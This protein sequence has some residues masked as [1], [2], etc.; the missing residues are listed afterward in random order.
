MIS[1]K[2]RNPHCEAGSRAGKPVAA[3][4]ADSS[5]LTFDPGL[6]EEFGAEELAE[7]MA[8]RSRIHAR[9]GISPD[10]QP[11]ALRTGP[12]GPRTPGGK[13]TSSANSLKHGLASGRLII[14]GEDAADF[15]ALL[16]DL[17]GD[18]APATETE[19]L[20]VQQMAQSW[21]LLQRA[22]RFQNQAFTETRC[23]VLKL[24]LFLR[25]QTT[26]ERAFYKALNTLLKLQKERRKTHPE[27]VSQKRSAPPVPP[28]F[29]SKKSTRGIRSL[30][31]EPS[32]PSR[33]LKRN[34]R[35]RIGASPAQAAETEPEA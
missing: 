11:P 16:S 31:S 34:D 25:Y 32:A 5:S 14:P 4:G 35:G 29:V 10:P 28:E 13:A 26:Y 17:T 8:L 24:T 18:H 15:E 1:R 3:S 23:D 22:I 12:T 27:F 21:W 19:Q 20:L 6:V 9:A 33:L 30:E 2:L 7:M